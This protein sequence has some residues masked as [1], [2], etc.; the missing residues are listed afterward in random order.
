M[1]TL[2]DTV[3]ISDV[4]SKPLINKQTK[5]NRLSLKKNFSWSLAGNVTYAGCQGAIL[6]I[7]AKLTIPEMVGR[8]ALG[9]AITAPIIM[10]FN[11]QLREIQATDALEEYQFGNYLA[12]RLITTALALI[13]ITGISYWGEYEFETAVLILAMGFSKAFQSI[14]DVYYGF[15]QRYERLDRIAKSQIIKGV[16]SLCV[17]GIAVLTTGN[18]LWGVIGFAVCWALILTMYDMPSA[19]MIKENGLKNRFVLSPFFRSLLP[20]FDWQKL[21]RLAWLALPLGGVMWLTSLKPNIPRYFIEHYC[22]ERYLGIFA[23][24]AYLHA[25]SNTVVSALGQSAM[26]R[27]ADYHASGQFL[28][29]RQLLLR[30]IGLGGAIG[31]AGVII[32]MFAGRLILS[33][34]YGP[35]YADHVDVFIWLMFSGALVFIATFLIYGV[36]VFRFFRV[37]MLL[38]I[39]VTSV[40]CIASWL[41]IPRFGILGAAY[42]V[43]AGSSVQVIGSA[44]IVVYAMTVYKD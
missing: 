14:S 39:L 38:Y 25:V 7:L 20:V 9:L 35:D 22:G 26:P 43:T 17:M 29:F 11:L 31:L 34:M 5:A 8:F 6:V 13:I 41:L 16:S 21:L 32:S 37:Q 10:L 4:A 18:V 1:S 44:G 33:L 12:L 23:A 24:L 15:M 42:A 3:T 2:T 40:T 36:I 30:L 19:A 28:K 27:L